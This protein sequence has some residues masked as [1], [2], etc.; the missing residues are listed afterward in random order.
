MSE[1]YI[2]MRTKNF[3]IIMIKV[4]LNRIERWHN[5]QV[6]KISD[7]D[8]PILNTEKTKTNDQ[9]EKHLQCTCSGTAKG[10]ML[11]TQPT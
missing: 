2:F 5:N 3:S 7:T 1:I 11:F 9:F 10:C 6:I 8:S 4:N